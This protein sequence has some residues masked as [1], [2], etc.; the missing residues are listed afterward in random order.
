LFFCGGKSAEGG[1][2]KEDAEH[3]K[4][5]EQFYDDKQPQRAPPR[6]PSEAIAVECPQTGQNL[7]SFHG[8]AMELNLILWC[9][10]MK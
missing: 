6:H 3:H 8:A 9:K 5:D 2:K 4:D 1:F 10:D 7:R